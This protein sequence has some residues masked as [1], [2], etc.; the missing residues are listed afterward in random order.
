[1]VVEVYKAT[2]PDNFPADVPYRARTTCPWTGKDIITAGSDDSGAL[3][4]MG[5][6]LTARKAKYPDDPKSIAFS[7]KILD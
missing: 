1:M 5:K 2:E 4:A 7:V 6:A 3:Y